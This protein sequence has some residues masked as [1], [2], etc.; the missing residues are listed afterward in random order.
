MKLKNSNLYLRALMPT[1]FASVA[2]S[3]SVVS[4]AEIVKASVASTNLLN[5][6]TAW[7]GGTVPGAS[8]VALWNSTVTAANATGSQTIV[9]MGGDFSWQ[10]IKVTDVVGTANQGAANV[11]GIRMLNTSSANTLTL[12]SLGIDMSAATQALLIQSKVTLGADQTWN[13]KNANTAGAPLGFNN[14]ED[15]AFGSLGSAAAFDLNGK[16][17]TATGLG[18][19]TISSGYTI[20]N[21]TINVGNNLFV[22]Q[23]GNSQT[24]TIGSNVALNVATG[25]Q[26]RLQSNSGALNSAAAISTTGIL[27][28]LNNN[29]GQPVTQS[30]SLTMNAGSILE[31]SM[32]QP[33]L[34]T[35]SGSIA[36]TG[37]FTWNTTGTVSHA[38][39][40]E[41]TGNLT[42]SSN[43]LYQNTNTSSLN[44]L[45]RFSGDNSGYTGTFTINGASGNRSLRLNAANSGSAAATWNVAANNILQV[46]GVA[47][48]LGTLNGLGTVTNA[49]ATNDAAIHVGAGNFSGSI[50]N[51]GGTMSVVKKTSG[52]LLLSG[53]CTYSGATTV[54]QGILAISTVGTGATPITVA[55]GAALRLD[56]ASQDAQR[57]VPS[58]ALGTTTGSTLSV[59][60]GTLLNPSAAPL[61]TTDL[62]VNA[63]TTL[64]Y[65]GGNVTTGTFPLVSYINI[66]GTLG[67]SGL[68]LKLPSRIVGTLINNTAAS[69]IDV[70]ITSAQGIRWK[71]SVDNNWD[72]DPT[73]A[74]TTGTANWETTVTTAATR[75]LQ[76]PSGT[77]AAL[78]DDLAAGTGDVTVNLTTTHTPTALSIN[79]P[80]RNYIFAGS[81]SLSGITGLEKSGAGS[82]QISN[83]AANDYTGGTLLDEGSIIL[84]DGVTAGAGVIFGT[85]DSLA[86]TS[87]VLNRP[88]DHNFTNPL[89]GEGKLVKNQANIVTI[90]NAYSANYDLE[91]NA[92]TLKCT[93]G[94]TLSR[95][96]SGAGN[97]EISGGI[98]TINGSVP[99]TISG[100]TTIRDTTVTFANS[101]GAAIAGDLVIS[102]TARVTTTVGTQLA[103]TA[104]ISVVGSNGDSYLPGAG[105]SAEVV[106]NVLV[107]SSVPGG[108]GAQLIMRNGMTV[109][110][111]ATLNSGVLGVGSGNTATVK[112]ISITAT[113]DTSAILRVAGSAASSTLNIGDGGVTAS[114]GSWQIKFNTNNQ[115]A[116]VNLGG[117]VTTTGNFFISNGGY[118]GANLNVINLTGTRTFTIAENTTTSISPDF[119]D[120]ATLTADLEDAF[121]GN[122][123]KAGAGKLIL[124]P[125]CNAGHSGTTSVTAGALI[126]N[127]TMPNQAPILSA[128][129]TLGGNGTI[130]AATTIPSGAIISPGDGTA[131]TLN[132]V[133][134]VT[135]ASGSTYAV[136]I[137]GASAV[138]RIST[139]AATLT[140]NGT[141]AVTLTGYTP[142]LDDVFDLADATSIS[143]TPTFDFTAA[144]LA[145]GLGWDTSSF[146]TD[147]KIKVVS[148]ATGFDV[149]ATTITDPEARGALAD[150]DGDGVSN[151]LEYVLGGNPNVASQDILPDSSVTATDLVFSFKRRDDSEGDT[152]Q[153]VEVSS[154]LVNWN[155]VIPIT[156]ASGGSVTVVENGTADDDVTVTIAKG[157]NA[158]L[159][160]RLKVTKP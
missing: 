88:D 32:T 6:S 25:A 117:D 137:T 113:D 122:L 159:F 153:V 100:T 106:T 65:I 26:L 2:F 70:E 63:P 133:S 90:P 151:I 56:I 33:G 120:D 17:V 82:L 98:V 116:I 13:I 149:F 128:G 46:N 92:G 69:R 57:T 30:G 68:T 35:I 47:V 105:L 96:I 50:S 14:N 49:H 135:L 72:V 18:Q 3:S 147:G 29:S 67:F 74:G 4:A 112:A 118:T 39:G 44:G 55:D 45:V 104:S 144:P 114:G 76:A 154:D 91:V 27:R 58:V 95:L 54:E 138:D 10:G 24:M 89:A 75:F 59:N 126:V 16:T 102:G 146:A 115:D 20:S 110:G 124:N 119:A 156:A 87:L 130:T 5:T 136:D 140:L 37:A 48:Q 107:N 53:N 155:T 109:T 62:T 148:V 9:Q 86:G 97:L 41:V 131:A 64:E 60:A 11:S 83:T 143:G 7:V 141:I 40:I 139:P 85:I 132:F 28:L 71:G 15:L 73:G 8:D 52:A 12:G 22:I 150:A 43:V 157:A 103:P 80:T 36:A 51:G 111:L 66:N 160:A 125:L 1:V 61:V 94:G 81:G 152:T 79:N 23:G 93:G 129:A 21:G 19:I 123:V 77:D 31:T 134:D 34:I 42:G 101:A 78:F 127:G 121:T 142:V 108:G 158:T 145:S 99:N 84:G 38:N